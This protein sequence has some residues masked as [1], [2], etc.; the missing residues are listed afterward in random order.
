MKTPKT[1][2]TIRTTPDGRIVASMPNPD[3]P[4]TAEYAL[5]GDAGQYLSEV[6]YTARVVIERQDGGAIVGG[7]RAHL[8]EIMRDVDVLGAHGTD[9]R[10]RAGTRH[11]ARARERLAA[12]KTTKPA[13]KTPKK[14]TG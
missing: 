12:A 7:D 13:T 6:G 1:K 10:D 2:P 5:V 3:G 9:V 14:R 11:L 4:K 8:D